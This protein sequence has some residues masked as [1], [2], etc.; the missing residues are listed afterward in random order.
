MSNA[1]YEKLHSLVDY[2]L[3]HDIM[4]A[5]EIAK[6]FGISLKEFYAEFMEKD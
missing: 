1:A 5:Q 3:K 2:L 4:E 6:L